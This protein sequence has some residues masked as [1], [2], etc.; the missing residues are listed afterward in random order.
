MTH[1]LAS[2]DETVGKLLRLQVGLEPDLLEPLCAVPRRILQTEHFHPPLFLVRFQRRAGITRVMNVTRQRNGAFHG[3]LRPRAHGKMSRRRGV[4]Q[5]NDVPVVPCGTVDAREVQPYRRAAQV[6]RVGNQA[7]PPKVS[8]EEPLAEFDSGLLRHAIET[9][10]T[11]RLLRA[12][13]DER[14]PAVRKGIAVCLVPAGGCLFEVEREGVEGLAGTQPDIPAA[15]DINVGPEV[16]RVSRSYCAIY[17]IGR[18]NQSGTG[19]GS[20]ATALHAELQR[21]AEF[22][23]PAGQDVEQC[24]PADATEPMPSRSDDAPAVVDVD[25]VPVHEVLRDLAVGPGVGFAE[26]PQGPSENTTPQPN[27]LPRRFLSTTVIARDGSRSFIW[28]EKYSP[29]GPPPMTTMG[30]DMVPVIFAETASAANPHFD[31]RA[32]DRRDVS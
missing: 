26:T 30:L 17:A 25:V 3:Q 15:P 29:A 28:M 5:Q 10:R 13:D 18:N 27:V 22:L 12:L 16:I 32:M 9:V 7:V 1:A 14:A 24:L 8:L 21:D 20:V 6:F 4:T 19:R 31:G 23:G 11:P 2:G